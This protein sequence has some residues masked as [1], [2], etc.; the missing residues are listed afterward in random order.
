MNIRN[1]CLIALVASV[2]MLSTRAQAQDEGGLCGVENVQACLDACAAY[3]ASLPEGD[4]ST[5]E[6][7]IEHCATLPACTAVSMSAA[8]LRSA[9]SLCHSVFRPRAAPVVAPS[10]ERRTSTPAFCILPDGSTA[11]DAGRRRCACPSGF[12]PMA[13]AR[14]RSSDGLRS[15]GIPRG[16]QVFVCA[17]PLA[18]RGAPG[19][20][21]E[22]SSSLES[23]ITESRSLFESL[24]TPSEGQTLPDACREAGERLATLGS[25]S[26][27]VD[28]AGV[29]RAL[30]DLQ[31]NQEDM[32]REIDGTIDA[33]STL[34]RRVDVVVE[35]LIEGG[36]DTVTYTDSEGVTQVY[37]C[38]EVLAATT[39]RILEAARHAAAESGRDIARDI[40]RD[41]MARMRAS[42]PQN[43]AMLSA[44]GLVTFNPL[45]YANADRGILFGIGAELTV[46]I[47]LGGGWNVHGGIALGYGG[48]DLPDVTNVQG[49]WH[50]GFGAWVD[51][52]VMIGFGMLG[53]HR[54]RP[55][56]FSVHSVYGPYLDA[57][58]RFLPREEWTPVAT[59]RGFVGASPRWNGTAWQVEADG[60]LMALIGIAHF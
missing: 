18:L 11:S 16:H 13:V 58:F 54:F 23:W 53:T 26:G 8:R 30:A 2:S 24:C 32:Q 29:M 60:G 42:Q 50:L 39:H 12:L 5:E 55:D 33:L 4:E 1:L 35:C 22:R 48:P 44:Y 59:I 21:E 9:R 49:A 41:E 56:V 10:T 47:G 20:L 45:H 15:L 43:F 28:L 52:G 6:Q 19:S 14:Y 17:S 37:T 7:L 51:P 38:T 3:G 36:S 46:G 40:A 25:G 27:P 57:T 34:S 31:D